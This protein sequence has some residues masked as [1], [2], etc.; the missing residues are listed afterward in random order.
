[1]AEDSEKSWFLAQL[2]PNSHKI[3]ERNLQRQGF[4]T[5][6]PLCKR[7]R[8]SRGRSQTKF[9]PLFPGYIFFAFESA[10]NGWRSV[11]CTLGVSRLVGFGASPTEV[12]GPLI[13]QLKQ[14]YDGTE[15]AAAMEKLRPGDSIQL[16]SGPFA[17]FISNVEA[18]DAEKRIWVLIDI[19]G[20]PSRV[21]VSASSPRPV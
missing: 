5:Y 20:R 10:D 4:A 16:C 1:M 17:D 19:L 21:A 14:R 12:P 11:A 7:T 15:D 13:D 18:I 6:L 2:K 3:A 8:F 9:V